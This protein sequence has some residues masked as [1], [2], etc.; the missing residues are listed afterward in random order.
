MLTENEKLTHESFSEKVSHLATTEPRAQ[1]RISTPLKSTK[2][3]IRC[4]YF[5]KL[6]EP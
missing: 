5:N 6:G 1:S 4:K 2:M 3:Q